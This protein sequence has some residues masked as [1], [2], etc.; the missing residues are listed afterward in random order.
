MFASS[1][2]ESEEAAF[3]RSSE[4]KEFNIFVSAF[5]ISM[6]TDLNVLLALTKKKESMY[7][8]VAIVVFLLCVYSSRVQFV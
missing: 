8:A 6:G 5:K 7:A 1:C 4:C 3:G 2:Q